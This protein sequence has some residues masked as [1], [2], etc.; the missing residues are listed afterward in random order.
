MGRF[1]ILIY[2]L[3]II[4]FS[5]SFSRSQ[6]WV[7]N[8]IT[9]RL[10]DEAISNIVY[11]KNYYYGIT[12]GNINNSEESFR[13]LFKIN[14]STFEKYYFDY[15]S[16]G[17]IEN[18][19]TKKSDYLEIEKVYSTKNRLWLISNQY[20]WTANND[21]NKINIFRIENDSIFTNIIGYREKKDKCIYYNKGLEIS[22]IDEDENLYVI[23]EETMR[24]TGADY[25]VKTIRSILKFNNEGKISESVLPPKISGAIFVRNLIIKDNIKTFFISDENS[26]DIVLTYNE[27][28]SLIF[29]FN[30]GDKNHTDRITKSF[31]LIPYGNINTDENIGHIM[32]LL[33]RSNNSVHEDLKELWLYKINP[34]NNIDS[35]EINVDYD[36][37]INTKSHYPEDFCFFV[38]KDLLLILNRNGIIVY[39][40][41]NK[42]YKVI[43]D[44]NISENIVILGTY[45]FIRNL[46]LKDENLIGGYTYD[47]KNLDVI[48]IHSGILIL[49]IS[50]C[51]K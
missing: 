42:S 34:F 35:I 31:S 33:S 37:Y 1:N 46:Y 20:G 7:S 6:E 19:L 14:D 22:A 12:L 3:F 15:D 27:N 50:N 51:K 8:R 17:K 47:D 29:C 48:D 32:W 11:Y 4:G 39:N 25:N 40:L 9:E 21:D 5:S 10:K 41:T 26:N 36:K 24:K 45:Q 23:L 43:K 30:P 44:K 49:D 2:A 13:G 28:D 16:K 38:Y 18:Y